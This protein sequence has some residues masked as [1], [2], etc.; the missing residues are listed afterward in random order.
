GDE[1]GGGAGRGGRRGERSRDAGRPRP[2]QPARGGEA[3]LRPPARR[4]RR[5]AQ[6]PPTP[7]RAA[8]GAGRPAGS[9]RALPGSRADARGDRE[10]ADPLLRPGDARRAR[11][12]RADRPL[13]GHDPQRRPRRHPDPRLPLH[14]ELGLA[15]FPHHPRPRRRPRH[16]L[17][18]GPRR[19][20]GGRRAAR[21]RRQ[22]RR[23]GGRA[24]GD[25]GDRPR[26]HRRR[27]VGQL[28]LLRARR[29]PGRGG[30]GGQARAPPRRPAGG[31]P[32]RR[33]PD[34]QG[35]RRFQAGGGDRRRQPGLGARPLPRLLLG[36]ARRRRERLRDDRALRPPRA[37]PLRPL[38]RRPGDR[39][40]LPGVFP[41][42]GQLRP[43]PGPARAASG[44]LHRLP[45]RRPRPPRGR[46]H[47]VGPPRPR[48][49]RRLRAGPDGDDGRAG[50]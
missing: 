41:R 28:R 49:R 30:G 17:R 48:P 26:G 43:G 40:P 6:H 14:A 31:H 3:A 33:R 8:L 2:V 38:P 44:R 25:G 23:A 4:L 18:H 35:R 10:R 5:P 13:P 9:G 16:L 24:G 39:P 15:H 7:R 36:D 27:D 22:A 46:R 42:R 11:A 45:A 34:L 32:R 37:D 20:R 12:R 19:R 50:V 29:A 21:L 1:C 47:A